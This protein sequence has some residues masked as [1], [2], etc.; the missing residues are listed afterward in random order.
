MAASS[1]ITKSIALLV[2]SLANAQDLN[3]NFPFHATTPVP[4]TLSVNPEFVKETVYK[5]KHYRPS[6]DLLDGETSNAGWLEGPPREDMIALAKYW[7]KSYDWH[8]IQ[9]E[10]NRNFSHFAV[11]IQSGSGPNS[12]IPIHF[13]HERSAAKNALPLILLHGWPSTHLEW[14]KVIGPL[15]SPGDH[16]AQAF[17]VVAPDL[18]GFGFSPAPKYTNLGPRRMGQALHQLMG[19]LGYKR[20]GVVGTDIGWEVGLTMADSLPDNIVGYFSDFWVAQPNSTDLERL[21]QN[22]T[23]EEETQYISAFSEWFGSHSSYST[24]HQQAPLA[25][26]QAMSDTPVGFA[27]WMWHL[28]HTVSDGH[29]YSFDELITDAMM[30]FIQGT[31]GN[32]RLYK[33]MAK[34]T[35]TISFVKVP[36]GV[37]EWGSPNG[38]FKGIEKF[39]S[40]PRDWLQRS[41]NL[42]YFSKHETGGHFPAINEPELWVRDVQE[43]F[44]SLAR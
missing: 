28:V 4:Y 25:I 40:V 33:E 32:L 1:W 21:A 10:I 23:T 11:N 27:G 9:N 34:D 16:G 37:S 26:G 8:Q 13:V 12:Q 3:F 41:V 42:V 31:F 6:I 19:Q 18:P 17:H 44:G 22:K 20:Y 29:K 14:S 35:P 15:V 43:F 39:G 24:V 38:F 5:A 7:G 30:L 2:I 36:T